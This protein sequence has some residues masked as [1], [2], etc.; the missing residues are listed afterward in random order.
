VVIG[1]VERRDEVVQLADEQL[2]GPEVSAPLGQVRAAAVAEL[3]VVDNG[4]AAGGQVGQGQQVVVCGAGTAVQDDQRRCVAV[5]LARDPVPGLVRLAA[6]LERNGPLA[7]RAGHLPNVPGGGT[8]AP[9][10]AG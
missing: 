10:D 3:V 1:D 2:D 6:D 9:A 4:P 5:R 7:R 8:P